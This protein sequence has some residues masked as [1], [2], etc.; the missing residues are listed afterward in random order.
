[1][2]F[3]FEVSNVK[4]VA[5]KFATS[6]LACDAWTSLPVKH[7]ASTSNSE[8][9]RN[10]NCTCSCWR[11]KIEMPTNSWSLPNSKN[12]NSSRISALAFLRL[13][14]F[15]FQ[16]KTGNNTTAQISLLFGSLQVA[17]SNWCFLALRRFR[18][19]AVAPQLL[20]QLLTWKAPFFRLAGSGTKL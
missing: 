3:T 16:A 8:V 18:V 11:P 15:E 14:K 1:M 17:L 7:W 13:R 4:S 2:F 19:V 6:V 5:L 9:L 10:A 20:P 12:V